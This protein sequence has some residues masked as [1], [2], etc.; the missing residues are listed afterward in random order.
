[1]A[2]PPGVIKDGDRCEFYMSNS[3][4]A[5]QFTPTGSRSVSKKQGERTR[6]VSVPVEVSKMLTAVSDGPHDMIVEE[7]PDGIWFFPFSQFPK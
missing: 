5:V 2:V 6:M 4:F 1:M 7:R 3:G